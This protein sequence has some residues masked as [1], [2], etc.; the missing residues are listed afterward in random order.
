MQ[1]IDEINKEIE[2]ENELLKNDLSNNNNQNN[3]IPDKTNIHDN[4]NKNDI[5]TENTKEELYKGVSNWVYNP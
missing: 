5:N 4:N 2:K 1:Q 3:I